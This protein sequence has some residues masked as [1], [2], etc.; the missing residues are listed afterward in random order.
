[1]LDTVLKFQGA[2]ADTDSICKK[3]SDQLYIINGED[4]R[5]PVKVARAANAFAAFL[6]DAR[7][8]RA[9]IQGSGLEL[10][11]IFPNV[12]IMQLIGVD[13]QENDLGDYNEAGV[14]F[15]VYENGGR[16]RWPFFSAVRAFM[17]GEATSY[18]HELPVDQPFTMHAGRFI[19]G[20]PKW[21]AEIDIEQTADT[22]NTSLVAD[23]RPVF[24]FRCKA[25]GKRTMTDQK[26]PSF[27]VRNGKTYK[28]V[29]VA[30]GTGVTFSVGGEEPEL[31]DHPI[32]ERLR[33][34]GLPKKPIFSGSVADMNMEFDPP[35]VME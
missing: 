13:Y 28:T 34:L 29:G 23:G 4:I 15:Y 35:V 19:W 26:Q 24:S 12:A 9:W 1:M 27:G 30:N 2:D 20:Y 33:A 31:G 32:A 17:R 3:K 8:A 10:I 25:G 18:I 7:A 16:K 11:E 22:F 14:S 21:I 5:L 6:V